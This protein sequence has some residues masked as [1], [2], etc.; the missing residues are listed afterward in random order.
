MGT[1]VSGRHESVEL[2]RLSRREVLEELVRQGL[3]G[4]S[5]IKSE[6]LSYEH[7]WETRMAE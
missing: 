4:L 6:C 3:Y 2:F 7:Y 5:R 1:R